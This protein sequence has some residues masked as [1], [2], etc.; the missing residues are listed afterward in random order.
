MPELEIKSPQDIGKLVGW[1]IESANVEVTKQGAGA[2]AFIV[3]H[4]SHVAAEKEVRLQITPV[5]EL[6]MMANTVVAGSGLNIQS[7]DVKE[8]VDG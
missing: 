8:S 4:I 2:V 1:K 7:T 6:T 3:L 5:P